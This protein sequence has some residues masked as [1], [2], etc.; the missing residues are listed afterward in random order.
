MTDQSPLR[1]LLLAA[2]PTDKSPIFVYEFKNVIHRAITDHLFDVDFRQS[3]GVPSPVQLHANLRCQVADVQA[4]L[5]RCRP[6]VVHF[7][8]HMTANVDGILLMDERTLAEG[9]R[10]SDLLEAEL[11]GQIM[12]LHDQHICCVLLTGCSSQAMGEKL[13]NEAN[14]PHVVYTTAPL[15]YVAC[16][17]WS[18]AWYAAVLSGHSVLQAAA[19]AQM[20]LSS[21]PAA[22]EF[23]AHVI[24]CKGHDHLVLLPDQPHVTLASPS[25]LVRFS[26]PRRDIEYVKRPRLWRQL[27][28]ALLDLGRRH[29]V[30]L[31][32]LGG[33][34]KSQLA[35]EYISEP[36]AGNDRYR[37]MAW[38]AAEDGGQ[39]LN[40]YL[41]F[42]EQYMGEAGKELSGQSS[43]AVIS[44]VRKWLEAQQYWLLVYDNAQSW[45]AIVDFLPHTHDS[46]T[47]HILVTSR[48][49]HWPLT[50]HKLEVDEMELWESVEL[51]K[52]CAG[53]TEGD[54]SQNVDICTLADR[55]GRLPLALSQ[56][57]AY[58]ARQ[59]VSVRTYLD[60]Y[61]RLL[62]QKETASLSGGDPHA[63]VAVT[64]DVTRQHCA[65]T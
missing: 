7:Y 20:Q 47:R 16:Q 6:H 19:V 46:R 51:V 5:M 35:L 33:V 22:R 4:E 32:G 13:L 21:D 60:A 26:I 54:H 63:I 52:S 34:G 49:Q 53:L 36:P 65:R 24:E 37:L 40:A 61:E 23:G 30:V 58:I 38:F 44:A 1:I 2:S 50:S 57:A 64:W 3:S 28:K 31:T 41:A 27:R 39:L 25:L 45:A 43:A 12:A 59:A 48:H 9:Q 8:A 56:A 15:H 62:M 18:G 10:Q 14:V 17:V 42:A 55:L 11:L 29:F